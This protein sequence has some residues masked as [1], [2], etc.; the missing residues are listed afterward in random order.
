MG[1][2]TEKI[3]LSRYVDHGTAERWQHAGRVL[4][5]TQEA[6]VLAVRALE[7]HFL[8]RLYLA[9]FISKNQLDAAMRFKRDYY[10]AGMNARLSASYAPVRASFSL[11]NGWDE[12]S[13]AEEEAYARWRQAMRFLQGHLGNLLVSAICYEEVP[14]CKEAL[15]LRSGLKVL[16]KIYGLREDINEAAA[17]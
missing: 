12:R 1:K 7:E 8:D 5:P 14:S 4:E 3:I 15:L 13:D 16:V 9:G 2:K 6:G 11:Y 10:A 17:R